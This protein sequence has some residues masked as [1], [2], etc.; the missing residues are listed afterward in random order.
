MAMS[1]ELSSYRCVKYDNQTY[2][3]YLS[4]AD[5]EC[6][7]MILLRIFFMKFQMDLY[8]YSYLFPFCSYIWQTRIIFFNANILI[9][10]NSEATN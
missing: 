9:Q 8:L 7:A 3:K 6:S 2:T 4:V 5:L 1:K 10:N